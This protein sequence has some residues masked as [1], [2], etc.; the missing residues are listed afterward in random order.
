MISVILGFI[1]TPLGKIA[2]YIGVAVLLI[3]IAFT[4]LKIHDAGIRNEVLIKFN[5][6]QIEKSL[7]SANQ[8]IKQNE[9]IIKN[10]NEILKSVGEKN[11]KLEQSLSRIDEYLN[12][13]NTIKSD[14]ESSSILKNTI[15]SL[16]AIK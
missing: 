7:E 8:L 12:E 2:T 14:K 5:S 13:P 11:E 9:I 3:G 10:Q 15:K 4:T 1:S 16:K 6:Q